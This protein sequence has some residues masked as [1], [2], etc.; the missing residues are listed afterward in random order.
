MNKL[1]CW[2]ALLVG[3]C[4]SVPQDETPSF[5][6]RFAAHIMPNSITD[7]GY[8]DSTFINRAGDRI[9]FLHT[10]YSPSVLSGQSSVKQ[11]AHVQAKH[12][13]GHTTT[14]GVEWNTDLYYVGW[15][16]VEWSEPVN[17]GPSINTLGMECCVWLNDDETEIIFNTVSDLDGDGVDEDL[18]L[19]PTGNYRATRSN[20]DTQWDVPQPMPGLYG[21]Q[22]QGTDHYRHDIHKA[23]SGDL[24]LWE[25]TTQ[26]DQL[27]VYGEC[28]DDCDGE[29]SYADPVNIVNTTNYETQI[30]VDDTETRMVFNHRQANGE[31]EL[32]TR[33]RPTI[34]DAW[35]PSTTIPTPGFAD[36]NG[37]NIWGEPSFDASQSFMLLTRFNTADSDCWTPDLIVSEIDASGDFQPPIIIN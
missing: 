3:A 2:T 16:G 25:Q 27:L 17:L 10:I 33:Q 37:S 36:S 4:T 9:Y 8:I 19:R 22:S 6:N 28:V 12:L 31:T 14:T 30:W 23:P 7:G 21:I 24:Y 18:G 5:D 11:C 34:T 32:Y 1:S 15:D 26:D 20:R 35:E 13:P 29:P